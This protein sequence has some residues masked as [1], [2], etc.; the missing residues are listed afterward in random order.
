MKP[1][2]VDG[3]VLAKS[4]AQAKRAAKD[5]LARLYPG[6]IIAVLSV[7]QKDGLRLHSSPVTL[8]TYYALL[9]VKEN[10]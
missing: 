1:L 7:D 9:K 8:F 2:E 3:E 6:H 10:T 4:Y 5:E